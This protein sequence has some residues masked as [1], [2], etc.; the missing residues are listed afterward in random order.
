MCSSGR[1]GKHSRPGCRNRGDPA[2][3]N[4]TTGALDTTGMVP[5]LMMGGKALRRFTS[6]IL[7]HLFPI[8]SGEQSLSLARMNRAYRGQVGLQRVLLLPPR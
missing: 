2:A 4:S 3:G 6:I 1:P 8:P 5:A 7:I